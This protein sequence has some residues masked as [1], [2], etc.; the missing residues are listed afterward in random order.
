LLAVSPTMMYLIKR[1]N[2]FVGTRS[3]RISFLQSPESY[4]HA[5]MGEDIIVDPLV[6]SKCGKEFYCTNQ[7]VV[8]ILDALWDKYIADTLF[9]YC[10]V[11]SIMRAYFKGSS[12]APM[13]CVEM[14]KIQ[15]DIGLKFFELLSLMNKKEAMLHVPREELMVHLL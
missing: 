6:Q 9:Y 3:E 14:K 11:C 5:F 7:I 12:A 2:L 1:S 10:P 15:S 4:S 13:C 8:G